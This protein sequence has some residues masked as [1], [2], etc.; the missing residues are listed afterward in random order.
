MQ[1]NLPTYNLPAIYQACSHIRSGLL[2]LLLELVSQSN[3]AV[4]EK[5]ETAAAPAFSVIG[6]EDW[7]EALALWSSEGLPLLADLPRRACPACSSSAAHTVFQSYD[8]YHFSECELCG[9]WYVPLA[10]DWALFDRFLTACPAAAAVAK[11]VAT[12]RLE[13]LE[14]QDL[15]RFEKYFRSIM[16]ILPPGCLQRRYLDIGCGVGHSLTAAKTAGML[17]HGVEGDPDAV[18]LARKNHEVVVFSVGD[19]PEGKY[20]LV[21]MWETLEHLAD[22]LLMLQEVVLRLSP[23]GLVAVTVPNL[24]AIGLRVSR[25]KCSYA[26]GGFNSPGHI[27]FFNRRT[28]GKLFEQAGLTLIEVNYEYST[29]ANELFGYLGGLTVAEQP[30]AVASPPPY[31]SAI[32]NAIWPAVTSLEML[33]GTL[34]IMQCVACHSEDVPLFS[35]RIN[36]RLTAQREHVFESATQQ[37]DQLQNDLQ[38]EVNKRDLLIAELHQQLG[39][40]LLHKLKR[41][42]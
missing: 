19:L 3:D 5:G 6:V 36:P 10:V 32:I 12:K 35:S 16:D 20:D 40:S 9:T 26:Y 42:F 2:R 11:R 38:A 25:E 22:P 33:A 8:G 7:K 29:N 28:I 37:L 23:G 18:A 13:E 39:E 27:N 4:R 41:L 24:D 30:Y 17:P 31:F 34:P 14:S 21:S 1:D 15:P